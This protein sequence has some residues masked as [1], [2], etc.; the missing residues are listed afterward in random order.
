M[1]TA[2]LGSEAEVRHEPL[3]VGVVAQHLAIEALSRV[4]LVGIAQ[5]GAREFPP[6]RPN[7]GAVAVPDQNIETEIGAYIGAS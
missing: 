3:S 6:R 1:D 7:D 2:V 5:G 4:P